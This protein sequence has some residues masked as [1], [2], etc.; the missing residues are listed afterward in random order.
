MDTPHNEE[1]DQQFLNELYILSRVQSHHTTEVIGYYHGVSG[2]EPRWKR[3]LNT[4]YQ[5]MRRLVDKNILKGY[6]D[7]SVSAF[8]RTF[9]PIRRF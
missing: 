1:T 4:T 8:N 2:E 3:L 6:T 5:K 9:H 7:G